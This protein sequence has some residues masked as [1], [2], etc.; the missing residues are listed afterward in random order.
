[1]PRTL[2][3]YL[4]CRARIDLPL[5]VPHAAR[6]PRQ[7]VPSGELGFVRNRELRRQLTVAS[8]DRDRDR[9]LDHLL[10]ELAVKAA[11]V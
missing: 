4:A 10:A 11:H 8:L 7:L 9:I 6:F 1:V 5:D 3:T 2:S